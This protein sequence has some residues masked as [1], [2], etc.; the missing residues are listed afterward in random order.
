[1]PAQE[2][3]LAGVIGEELAVLILPAVVLADDVTGDIRL[4]VKCRSLAHTMVESMTYTIREDC[5]G[6]GHIL[7]ANTTNVCCIVFG[8]LLSGKAS[9][10]VFW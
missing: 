9:L 6:E 10:M 3:V 2:A 5:F 4:E 7:T 1:M 8:L